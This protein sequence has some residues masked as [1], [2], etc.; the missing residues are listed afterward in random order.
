V[1]EAFVNPS[2]KVVM[3][4]GLLSLTLDRVIDRHSEGIDESFSIIIEDASKAFTWRF[5]QAELAILRQVLE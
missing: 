2:K 4:G 3:S 1:S 5:T